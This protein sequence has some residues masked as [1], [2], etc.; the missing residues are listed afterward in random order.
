MT[1]AHFY[2]EW[3]PARRWRSVVAC[4]WQQQ[5]A[6]D[7]T[8]RVLPDGH[9]DVIIHPDGRIDVVGLH[10]RVDLP[11][12]PGGTAIQGIRLRPHA[13]AAAFGV[14]A[15]SL[16]NRTVPLE[17]I[18]GSRRARHLLDPRALDAWITAIEPDARTARAVRLVSTRSIEDAARALG[19]TSR[20]LRRVFAHDVGIGPKVFQRVGRLQ[21]FV[22]A[23]EQRLGSLGAAAIE[24]GYAD[25]SHMTRDVGALAGTTPERLLEERGAPTPP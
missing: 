13:V 8:Q 19:L 7:H 21:R 12:L 17:D 1:Q 18:L 5:V 23:A 10:D 20:Q 9:A 2:R 15:S 22:A 4:R 11:L 3:A 16:R 14:A 6:G 25:Q 24:A